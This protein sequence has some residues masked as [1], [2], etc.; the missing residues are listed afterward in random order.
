VKTLFDKTEFDFSGALRL[1]KG[2][3]KMA[4]LGWSSPNMWIMLVATPS[5]S[6]VKEAVLIKPK[7][8]IVMRTKDGDFA[9]WF[10]SIC[11]I[12]AEDW[13]MIG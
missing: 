7:P 12:L 13:V 9:V 11:D 6:S 5:V 8:F 4:R 10:P 3:N 1:L 2:G